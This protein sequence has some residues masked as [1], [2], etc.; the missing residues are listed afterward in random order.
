MQLSRQ[1]VGK[2]WSTG[3]TASHLSIRR[4]ADAIGSTSL[5]WLER[6]LLDTADPLGDAP[7]GL[8]G[9][10]VL[11]TLGAVGDACTRK[12]SDTR[13]GIT[14]R[15]DV[16]RAQDAR[17]PAFCDDQPKDAKQLGARR[18]F[19]REEQPVRGLTGGSNAS[20]ASIVRRVAP[21]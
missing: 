9:L 16:R 10:P 21:R 20:S 18:A 7:H 13:R 6:T 15:D 14:R 4:N 12:L 5:L 17:R 19:Y 8:A 11:G 2:C 1:T 3:Q